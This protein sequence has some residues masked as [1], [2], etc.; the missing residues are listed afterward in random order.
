M[1]IYLVVLSDGIYLLDLFDLLVLSVGIYLVDLFVE[2]CLVVLSDEIYLDWL[3]RL[4][5]L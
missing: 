4:P 2:I 5:W 1:E 3:E